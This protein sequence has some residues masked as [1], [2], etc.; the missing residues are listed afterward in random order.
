[1]LWADQVNNQRLI[2]SPQFKQL[3]LTVKMTTAL[4]VETSVTEFQFVSTVYE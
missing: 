3:I 4:F 2:P 1:M